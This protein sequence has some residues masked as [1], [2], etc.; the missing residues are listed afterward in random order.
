[1][2]YGYIK[3]LLAAIFATIKSVQPSPIS[4]FETPLKR[5]NQ[6]LAKRLELIVAQYFP[7]VPIS[8]RIL[9]RFFRISKSRLGSIALKPQANSAQSV[10]VININALF[11]DLTVPEYVIDTTLMHEFIHYGHGFNSP[12]AQKYRHPHLGGVV[13]KEF[14]ARGAASILKQQ[15]K[16]IKTEYPKLLKQYGLL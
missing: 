9:V 3:L 6:W 2:S 15:Q 7:E 11:K 1:M 8:N 4:Q 5:N 12:L 13:T 10:T 14:K 16:W